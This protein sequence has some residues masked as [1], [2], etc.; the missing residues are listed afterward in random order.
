MFATMVGNTFGWGRSREIAGAWKAPASGSIGRAKGAGGHVRAA[1][2]RGGA[3]WLAPALLVGCGLVVNQ[4]MIGGES[5]FLGGCGVACSDGLSCIAGVCTRSCANTAPDCS[6]L[7]SSA[8]CRLETAASRDGFCDLPCANDLSCVAVNGSLAC[9]SGF[10]RAPARPSAVSPLDPS[11]P[12]W[13]LDQVPPP[14]PAAR[15]ASSLVGFVLPVLE[16][17]SRAP[18]AGQGLTATLCS[19]IDLACQNPLSPPYSVQDGVLGTT[20]LPPGA[21]GVPVPEGFDGFIKFEVMQ[22]DQTLETQQFL[23]VSYFLG[24]QISGDLTQGPAIVMTQRAVFDTMIQQSFPGVDLAVVRG[25]GVVQLGAYDCNGEPANDARIELSM[26]GETPAGVVP[27]LLS[28]SRIPIA[29]AMDQTLYTAASGLVG[30]LGVPTGAVQAQAYR[31]GDADPFGTVQLGS[32]A[33]QISQASI[34]PAYRLDANLTGVPLD[35]P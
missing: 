7:V 18:L 28:A 29:Q 22:A 10:C 6:D 16:W 17:S 21:A 33:D 15:P 11:D 3:A 30:Y 34:R 20:V 13:C 26:A 27:F 12:W 24:G 32:L 4:G 1:A 35:A 5:H 31:R 23:P 9:Q 19:V 25:L 14:L 2:W 8:S